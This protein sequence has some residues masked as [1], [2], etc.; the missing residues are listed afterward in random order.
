VNQD[1]R[2]ILDRWPYKPGELSVRRVIGSDNRIKIQMRLNLGLL[3]MEPTGRPDGQRPF[4]KESLLEYYQGK[5]KDYVLRHDS[6][7]GFSVGAQGCAELRE[8]GVQY[9]HRYLSNFFLKEYAAVVRDTERNLVLL[10]FVRKYAR[11]E[12]DR[13]SLEGYR[14][15]ILMMNAQA[16]AHV[17][18]A[19]D[20]LDQALA[21]VNAGLQK[22]RAFFTEQDQP[23]LLRKSSEVQALSDL[24]DE[25]LSR[26]PRSRIDVL[27]E[28][29]SHA[30]EVE[31]YE[32]AARLR[33]EIEK[34]ERLEE[35]S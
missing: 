26:K 21:E 14:P 18:L 20:N 9:Y 33:D 10:D 6:E 4:G 23:D 1:I 8:E 29:M 28:R 35:T 30:V 12:A 7:R 2:Q 17:A 15:Y 24:R 32:R 31:Q 25:L 19:E 16:K 11:H 27:R 5:L 22:V 3:Q 13:S 34:L